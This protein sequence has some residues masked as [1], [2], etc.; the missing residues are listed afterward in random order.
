L[1]KSKSTFWPL[2]P[3]FLML[4]KFQAPNIHCQKWRCRFE[5]APWSSLPS[6]HPLPFPT[7]R[8]PPI[9]H[10]H[11][12]TD[13]LSQPWPLLGSWRPHGRPRG[14]GRWWK[15][16][17]AKRLGR[18]WGTLW[19]PRIFA[20]GPSRRRNLALLKGLKF[21]ADVEWNWCYLWGNGGT[22]MFAMSAVIS[23]HIY[24]HCIIIYI[25]IKDSLFLWNDLF[26]G[27]LAML[28]IPFMTYITH[29]H[30][31]IT[32]TKYILDISS[33]TNIWLYTLHMRIY[34]MN[35]WTIYIIH[36]YLQ[37]SSKVGIVTNLP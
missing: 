1:T 13:G 37:T 34:C 22:N 26:H 36:F 16:S 3:R 31:I 33:D 27:S 17:T 35:L 29:Y 8:W 21:G 4:K 9:R 14:A 28:E 10:P 18:G 25:Y 19:S 23:V 12:T 24:I 11:G 2:R 6:P 20:P 30:T 5:P 15:M 7:P 32:Q